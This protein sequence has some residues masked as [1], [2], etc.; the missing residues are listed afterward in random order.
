MKK[1]IYLIPIILT[2][3]LLTACNNDDDTTSTNELEGTWKL[4][5][6]E[7]DSESLVEVT[8]GGYNNS[9]TI[10]NEAEAVNADYTLT[11]DNSQ[12]TGEGSYDLQQTSMSGGYTE[13]ITTSYDNILQTG[14][15][16]VDGNIITV[17]GS[18]VEATADGTDII[19][20]GGEPQ[21]IE[22]TINNDQLIFSQNEAFVVEV[23]NGAGLI[24]TSTN[25]V[26]FSS[27]WERQ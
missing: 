17:E 26:V 6:L 23:D 16:S 2:A 21:T 19:E 13:S 24:N 3:L 4:V 22:Y 10:N 27:V 11:F 15:Y 12:F 20:T 5:S 9:I 18:F 8:A 14:S 7:I 25:D 1:F